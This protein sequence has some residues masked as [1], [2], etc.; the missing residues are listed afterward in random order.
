MLL[1]KPTL[2]KDKTRFATSIAN[3]GKELVLEK[4]LD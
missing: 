4:K 2:S 3:R 1:Q